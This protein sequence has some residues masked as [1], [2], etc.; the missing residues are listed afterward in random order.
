LLLE[1]AGCFLGSLRSSVG[2]AS[3]GVAGA[4]DVWF[5]VARSS[6]GLPGVTEGRAA[7]SS[8]ADGEDDVSGGGAGGRSTESNAD[9][10]LPSREVLS[11]A[12]MKSRSDP[13][14]TLVEVVVGMSLFAVVRNQRVVKDLA[15]A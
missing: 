14:V 2:V 10:S 5:A 4:E 12:G 9:E 13:K 15:A 11:V 8:S 1:D 6:D 7:F 3:V